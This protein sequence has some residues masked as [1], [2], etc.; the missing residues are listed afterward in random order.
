MQRSAPWAS[1]RVWAPD[2]CKHIA[3]KAVATR[4]NHREHRSGRDDRVNGVA[5]LANHRETSLR[6]E[7]MRGRHHIAGHQRRAATGVGT[8]II[9]GHIWRGKLFSCHSREGGNPGRTRTESDSIS[10][11]RGYELDS[12][13]RENDDKLGDSEFELSALVH[14]QPLTA[15]VS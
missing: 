9:E 6:G 3:A 14:N 12:R 7:R 4:L 8:G 11:A 5:A 15:L 2:E 13:L 1:I 10:A